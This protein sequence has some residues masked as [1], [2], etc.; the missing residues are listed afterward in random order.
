MPQQG[1]RSSELNTGGVFGQVQNVWKVE[2]AD[3][4]KWRR[5]NQKSRKSQQA[6]DIK[7]LTLDFVLFK[8][9]FGG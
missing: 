3:S 7:G 5:R 9:E 2:S 4:R 6:F 8:G 1:L